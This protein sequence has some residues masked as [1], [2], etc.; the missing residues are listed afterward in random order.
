LNNGFKNRIKINLTMLKT[1]KDIVE[2]WLPRYTKR[3]IGDFTKY[4]LLTNFN[5]YVE[6]FSEWYNVPIVGKEGNMPNASNGKITIINFGTPI[7]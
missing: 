5:H 6:L 1:K 7:A 4:I 3:K 2:N